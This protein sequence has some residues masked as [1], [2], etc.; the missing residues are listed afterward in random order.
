MCFC[1]D[2]HLWYLSSYLSATCFCSVLCF[3]YAF[4]DC[5]FIVLLFSL[6][7]CSFLFFFFFLIIRRPPRSTRTDTLFPYTTL[8]RS[9]DIDHGLLGDVD[10]GVARTVPVQPL[11]DNDE[12]ALGTDRPLL[13]R[14][15]E[16]GEGTVVGRLAGD[17]VDALVVGDELAVEIGVIRALEAALEVGRTRWVGA[18]GAARL[19][20]AQRRGTRTQEAAQ[21]MVPDRIGRRRRQELSLLRDRSTRSRRV[22]LLQQTH[23]VGRHVEIGEGCVSTCRSRWSP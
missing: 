10:P 20:A 16:I 11:A 9:W 22:V 8:F 18:A 2:S 4:V 17:G 6:F 1:V 7:F 23:D 3:S 12:G 21:L 13:G 15:A 5:S 14:L 19:D